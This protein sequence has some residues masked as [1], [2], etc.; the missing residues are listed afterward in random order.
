MSGGELEKWQGDD[1]CEISVSELINGNACARGKNRLVDYR[2]IPIRICRRLRGWRKGGEPVSREIEKLSTPWGSRE[3][4]GTGGQKK[5]LNGPDLSLDG[6][7]IDVCILGRAYKTPRAG[8]VRYKYCSSRGL[9]RGYRA[10]SFHPRRPCGCFSVSRVNTN[11]RFRITPTQHCVCRTRLFTLFGI[12]ASSHTHTHGE[13]ER[14]EERVYASRIL[15]SCG[16]TYPV[17]RVL[18]DDEIFLLSFTAHRFWRTWVKKTDP[19]TLAYTFR[20]N[21]YG[22]SIR[23]FKIISLYCL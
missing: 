21:V 4:R 14:P 11:Y 5:T 9:C 22:T 2:T 12:N 16:G 18:L 19:R 20:H 17:P 8:C 23:V 10:A 3:I 7:R 1:G 13:H 6:C 15:P